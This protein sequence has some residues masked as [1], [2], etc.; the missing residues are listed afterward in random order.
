MTR[1]KLRF[2]RGVAAHA[3]WLHK[4]AQS[5]A[6]A[7][8]TTTNTTAHSST[9]Q[10]T[11]QICEA[12][13]ANRY[14]FPE[15]PARQRQMHGDVTARLRELHHTIETGA[16]HREGVLSQVA[17]SLEAWAATVR[18]CLLLLLFVGGCCVRVPLGSPC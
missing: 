1:A 6:C 11:K 2:G 8:T 16:R 10:T 17:A 12:Y 3:T 15:D 5:N 7:R 14:P 13:G 9:R 18:C 4:M